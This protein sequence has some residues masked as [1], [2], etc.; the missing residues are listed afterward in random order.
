MSQI[1]NVLEDLF[2]VFPQVRQKLR[3]F[4]PGKDASIQKDADRDPASGLLLTK[5]GRVQLLSGVRGC[6]PTKIKYLGDPLFNPELG[7]F[8]VEWLVEVAQKLSIWLSSMVHAGFELDEEPAAEEETKHEG[9]H[10]NVTKI[11]KRKTVPINLRWIADIRYY[12]LLFIALVLLTVLTAVI[13]LL[14]RV[15]DVLPVI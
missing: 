9:G 11:A 10:V 6:D 13:R 14:R 4:Q 2:I 1:D 5:E 3:E 7:E 8:E 12:R 15:G